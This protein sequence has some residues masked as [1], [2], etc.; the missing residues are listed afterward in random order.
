MV[1]GSCSNV[2][3]ELQNPLL[4]SGGKSSK[5][6]QCIYDCPCYSLYCC[7]RLHCYGAERNWLT[8]RSDWL[9]SRL[10]RENT[11]RRVIVCRR[12]CLMHRPQ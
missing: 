10:R 1:A 8:M 9:G 7:H 2:A 3:C 4:G 5:V 11:A 12:D 6:T